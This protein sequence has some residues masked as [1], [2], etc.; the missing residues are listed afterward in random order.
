[1]GGRFG[2]RRRG[3]NSV[4]SI[5]GPAQPMK[6][7][8][9]KRAWSIRS[10]DEAPDKISLE[11]DLQAKLSVLQAML[12]STHTVNVLA[13]GGDNEDDPDLYPIR[14]SVDSDFVRTEALSRQN[15]SISQSKESLILLPTSNVSLNSPCMDTTQ[16]A[17]LK[18]PTIIHKTTSGNTNISTGFI[19]AIDIDRKYRPPAGRPPKPS[20]FFITDSVIYGTNAFHSRM[21]LCRIPGGRRASS[22]LLPCNLPD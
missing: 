17:N 21:L 5:K 4:S 13:L 22:R 10:Q 8:K 14:L 20:M 7:S 6:A 18:N 2:K 12:F 11:D 3:S 16:L 15:T 9:Y 19:E 1:M